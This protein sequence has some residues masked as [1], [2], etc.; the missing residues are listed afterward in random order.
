MV[1]TEH[2]KNELDL[3]QLDDLRMHLFLQP[4]P[5]VVVE[6]LDQLVKQWVL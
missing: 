6:K 4:I 2:K 5:L 1:H 3:N